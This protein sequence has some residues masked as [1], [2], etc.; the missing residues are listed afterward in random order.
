[1]GKHS[2]NLVTLIHGATSAI[3]N[4]C[5]SFMTEKEWFQSLFQ[6]EDKG[7]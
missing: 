4:F 3:R 1:M 7:V 6:K 5:V 2:P